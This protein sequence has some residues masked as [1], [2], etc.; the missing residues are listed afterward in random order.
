MTMNGSIRNARMNW[1]KESP[2]CRE[3]RPES[4][5]WAFA[6]GRWKLNSGDQPLTTEGLGSVRQDFLP[7]G[8]CDVEEHH[9]PAT[10]VTANGEVEE[11]TDIFR[12]AV[13]TVEANVMPSFGD[14]ILQVLFETPSIPA[15]R[16]GYQLH[17]VCRE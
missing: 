15:H 10:G 5:L 9:V 6:A 12:V 3:C 17:P 8:G 1:G 13:A 2:A 11:E 16:V 7:P 14:W 4:R